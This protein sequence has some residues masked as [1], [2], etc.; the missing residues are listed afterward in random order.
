MSAESAVYGF[1][2]YVLDR[3]R[4]LLLRDGN[5]V[6]LTPKAFD[7]LTV[8]VENE[9]RLVSKE[10][11]MRALWPDTVV[12]ESNLTFQV[13]ALRKALGDGRYVV[14]IPGRGYQFAGAVERVHETVVEQEE[15][16]TVTVSE[17]RRVIPWMA[18]AVAAAVAAAVAI[19]VVL[20]RRPAP[21][22]PG[23]RSIAVL[24]F[25]PIVAA[26][27]DESLELGMA[28]TLITRLSHIPQ[29]VVRPT[30]AVRRYSA[31]DQD[32]LAAGR[33]LRVDSVLDGNI[34]RAGDR[35]R[36]TVRLL[37]TTDGAPL[38]ATQF[39][40][41][42]GDLFAVQDRVADGV[43]R[44]IAP[45]LSG[46]QQQ[47]LSKKPTRDLGAYQLYTQGLVYKELDPAKAREYF[48]RAVTRDESFAAAW[49]AIAETWLFRGRFTN[50]P[51][52]DIFANAR[53]AAEKA[54]EIDPD[55]SD[56]HAALASVFSD[57]EWRWNDA[58]REYETA[59]RL[60]PNNATA[61]TG[62]ALLMMVRHDC[63][64]AIQ[65]VSRAAELD[66]LPINIGVSHGFVLREC[67]RSDE[68]VQLLSEWRKRHPDVSP[69]GLHLGMA[70][71]S[72][73]K[74]AEGAKV[75][76]EILPMAH[77]NSQIQALYAYAL[78]KSGGRDEALRVL[79]QLEKI[80]ER[81]SVASVNL[82]AA[83]AALGN[84]DRAFF[85]LERAYSDH[86]YLLRVVAVDP[87]YEPL[88]GDPRYADLMRRMNL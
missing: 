50:Y 14:T 62:Y 20:L 54:I 74:P 58:A 23:V 34:Q 26:Q 86:L 68:A 78:V 85:W 73:G 18:I 31:L 67:G 79:G 2:S 36:V 88:R 13:S 29:L 40:Q 76:R 5:A 12:E 3:P 80:G 25:R 66:P 24:P 81:E 82:A 84:R 77:N 35:V 1:G 60:N 55:L 30:S 63:G 83:Y 28:D 38:W 56:A 10:A 41:G 33:E 72:A 46:R 53:A 37:R 8:L 57:Y 87:A 69:L 39:D 15:R 64:A 59:I 32:P 21:A 47:L 42:A 19:A 16:T 52:H 51:P 44:S 65:H 17:E 4:R 43:A 22:P 49:A 61:H 75:M 6:A 48:Q 11:L 45:S 9:G 7:L 27:R 70:Y 71:T